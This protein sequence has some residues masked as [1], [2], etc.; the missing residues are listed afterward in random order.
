MGVRRSLG[1]VGAGAVA[2]LSVPPFGWW[3]LGPPALGV[4][5]HWLRDA[6]W[7]Q[8]VARA[9][10]FHLGLW[11]VGLFWV[12]EFTLPGTF[13]FI[14]VM[15]TVTAAPHALVPPA[16]GRLLAFPAAVVA[17]D[18]VRSRWPFEGLPLSGLDLSLS[19]SPFAVNAGIGGRLLLVALVAVAATGCAALYA[20]WRRAAPALVAAALIA[21]VTAI[22][23]LAP[24][25]HRT[26]AMVVGVVQGGGERGIR[27]DD[28][29][30]AEVFAAHIA[31]TKL[32][33]GRRLDLVLWPEDVIDV[34]R[35]EGSPE[36]VALGT[37]V[38]RLGAPAVVAGIVEDA[39]PDRFRNA[40][41]VVTPEGAVRDR[42]DKVRRVPFGEYFPFRSVIERL[43]PIP[44]RDAIA[45][46]GPGTLATSAGAM[47]VLVSYEVFFPD[48]ARAAVHADASVLLVPTNAS[49]FTTGQMPAQQLA[50]ARVRAHET[51]RWVVQAG[52]TGFSAVV[53]PGGRVVSHTDLGARQV[54]VERVELRTG[55]T[56][57]VRGGDGPLLLA[58]LLALAGAW[59]LARRPGYP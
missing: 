27:A 37:A 57:F 4:V 12:I 51:G 11:G 13:L 30:P 8:R 41:V 58:T 59:W 21:L 46:D 38:R 23:H 1:L 53:T 39:G 52:P 54:L 22:A 43:A 14:A 20:N 33:G 2:A 16:R 40:A 36:L 35:F 47:G 34:P 45:G 49:S 10:L 42:Y 28:A 31:A 48:R 18:A 9:A 17:A 29:N 26:G 3:F 6:S 24:D 15:V 25:G 19:G 55:D 56:W 5:A 32:L 7:G 50:A 44:S